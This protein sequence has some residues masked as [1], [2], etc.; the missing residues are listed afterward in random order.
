MTVQE[1]K[2]IQQHSDYAVVGP[3]SEHPSDHLQNTFALLMSR[4]I[5]IVYKYNDKRT[6]HSLDGERWSNN[7]SYRK[8]LIY[9]IFNKNATY[10]QFGMDIKMYNEDN[11]P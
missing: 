11:D 9:S 4:G 6:N 1:M 2:P 5:Y 10:T 7:Y 3:D 8:L